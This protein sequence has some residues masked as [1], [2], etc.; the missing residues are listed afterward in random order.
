MFNGTLTSK[1]VHLPVCLH[2]AASLSR[3]KLSPIGIP[4]PLR[5][6]SCMATPQGLGLGH[7]S[8]ATVSL[9]TA[10]KQLSQCHRMESS[11]ASTPI[12]ER[13]ERRGSSACCSLDRALK[14]ASHPVRMNKIS[15]ALKYTPCADAVARS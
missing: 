14:A 4:Q 11:V 13:T 2:L 9:A 1:K 12:E 5:N 10:A 3:S 7:A 6:T 15:P 8:Y